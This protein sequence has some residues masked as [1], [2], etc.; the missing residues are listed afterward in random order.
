M[1]QHPGIGMRPDDPDFIPGMKFARH[2]GGRAHGSVADGFRIVGDHGE[3]MQ[4]VYVFHLARDFHRTRERDA[5][6]PHRDG[7]RVAIDH[8]QPA[9]CIHNQPGS[10]VV[11]LV[12]AR[13]R[14]RHI[15]IDCHQGWRQTIDAGIA[16]GLEMG[17]RA[18]YDLR[19]GASGDFL[20]WPEPGM[21]IASALARGKPAT[22][23]AH[24]P[25]LHRA[26][27]LQGHVAHGR[28]I[29]VGQLAERCLEIRER[30]HAPAIER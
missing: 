11:P 12:D 22:V 30:V 10:S 17:R 21:I 13:D 2:Q 14:V 16:R 27:I 8:D 5:H 25:Q 20:A 3:V 7:H 29:P 1:R 18:R 19:R 23:H 6:I 4:R 26:R 28:P 24:H 15:E 9:A